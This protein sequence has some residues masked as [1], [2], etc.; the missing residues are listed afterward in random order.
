MKARIP[1]NRDQ[2]SRLFGQAIGQDPRTG[3]DLNHEVLWPYI[4]CAKD[5]V[6]DRRGDEETLPQ[7]AFWQQMVPPE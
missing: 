5:Q 3:T 2:P 7:T 1:L 4:C 6:A